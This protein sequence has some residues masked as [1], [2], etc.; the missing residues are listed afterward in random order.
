[1]H[2]F[3]MQTT[4]T[5][6]GRV[7]QETLTKKASWKWRD[8]QGYFHEVF[9]MKTSHLFFTLRMIWNHTMPE[10]VKLKPYRCYNFSAYYTNKYMKEAI[11]NIG[12]EL[13]KRT[14]LSQTQLAELQYMAQVVTRTK[15]LLGN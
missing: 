9:D 4:F 8:R 12:A 14:D 13:F 3:I 5:P 15:N 1:M 7:R 6:L 2:E 10:D 11:F